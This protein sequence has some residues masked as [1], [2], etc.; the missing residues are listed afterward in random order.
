MIDNMLVEINV[1]K[2]QVCDGYLLKLQIHD[3]D[4]Y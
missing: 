3:L 4:V 1:L 2:F